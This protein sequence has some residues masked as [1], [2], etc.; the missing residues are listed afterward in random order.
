VRYP[1]FRP[2]EGRRD[3]SVLRYLN[4]RINR[5]VMREDKELSERVQA[6]LSTHGYRPGPLS[7]LEVAIKDFHDRIRA[8]IPEVELPEAPP[9]LDPWQARTLAAGE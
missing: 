8:V 1:V 6:G 2:R 4:S 9:Y 3:Q 5:Q 7:T